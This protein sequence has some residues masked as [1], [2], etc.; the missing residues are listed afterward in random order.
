[1]NQLI[2]LESYY[3][4]RLLMN[5][6]LEK[7]NNIT[8]RNGLNLERGNVNLYNLLQ[9]LNNCNVCS[10]YHGKLKARFIFLASSSNNFKNSESC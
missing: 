3:I 5:F 9:Y 2:T 7:W 1:M 8:L 4:L 10:F 6:Q